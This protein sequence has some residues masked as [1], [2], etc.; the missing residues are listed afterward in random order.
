MQNPAQRPSMA[1]TSGAPEVSTAGNQGLYG[2][3]GYLN[4]AGQGYNQYQA[5]PAV[6]QPQLH[7]QPHLQQAFQ[8]YSYQVPFPLPPVCASN[9]NLSTLQVCSGAEPS[10]VQSVCLYEGAILSRQRSGN[11]EQ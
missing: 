3:Q 11:T 1:P 6:E 5:S 2:N 4:Y 10:L 7:Q 8:S 9:V